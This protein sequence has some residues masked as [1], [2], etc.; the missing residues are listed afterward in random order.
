MQF[1]GQWAWSAPEAQEIGNM[2]AS[3][4]YSLGLIILQLLFGC[5]DTEREYVCVQKCVCVLH[6]Y[7]C[8]CMY[9]G[10]RIACDGYAVGLV[11]YIHIYIYLYIRAYTYKHLVCICPGTLSENFC[12]HARVWV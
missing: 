9:V 4:V 1:I 11:I 6:V 10:N 5:P 12:V 7:V 3:D 2:I 8:I